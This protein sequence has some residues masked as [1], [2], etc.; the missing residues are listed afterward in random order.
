V[1]ISWLATQADV[2]IQNQG[3]GNHYHR[4]LNPYVTDLL[5]MYW[6]NGS[7]CVIVPCRRWPFYRVLF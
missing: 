4:T 3:I 7:P 5:E 2:Y 6:R 1:T